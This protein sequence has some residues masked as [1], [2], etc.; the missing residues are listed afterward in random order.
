MRFYFENVFT[1]MQKFFD[2]FDVLWD[3]ESILATNLLEKL[4]SV[5]SL[6]IPCF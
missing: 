3:S 1:F 2:I 6:L 5:M 4:Q